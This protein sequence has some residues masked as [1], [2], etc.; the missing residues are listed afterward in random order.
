MDCAKFFIDSILGS[1]QLVIFYES[2]FSDSED[3]NKT[4]RLNDTKSAEASESA[5]A[6]KKKNSHLLD[7]L[8]VYKLN[9]AQFKLVDISYLDEPEFSKQYLKS[10]CTKQIKYQVTRSFRYSFKLLVSYFAL[11]S[12]FCF[13]LQASNRIYESAILRLIRRSE[14]RARGRHFIQHSASQWPDT[15]R[16][17]GL[18]RH[19]HHRAAVRPQE[20]RHVR[21]QSAA[22]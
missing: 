9:E 1:S 8:K 6:I 21:H 5:Q 20:L 4:I 11:I 2:I 15:R 10:L 17:L 16:L 3:L 7:L 19:G 18:L 13:V 22:I 12:S 14:P